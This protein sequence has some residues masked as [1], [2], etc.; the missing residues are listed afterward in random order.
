MGGGGS[1]GA[2][3]SEEAVH[4]TIGNKTYFTQPGR[5]GGWG[6]GGGGDGLEVHI[7]RGARGINTSRRYPRARSPEGVCDGGGERKSASTSSFCCDIPS[8]ALRP[9]GYVVVAKC[10]KRTYQR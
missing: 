10:V 5:G 3:A 1:G 6:M 9:N 8:F 7:A 4:R 2:V